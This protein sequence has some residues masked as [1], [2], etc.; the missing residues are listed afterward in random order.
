MKP[1]YE[2]LI[3]EVRILKEQIE[4]QK[5]FSENFEA[6]EQLSSLGHWEWDYD[7]SI[8]SWSAEVF[9]IFG[10]DKNNFDVSVENFENFIHEEDIEQIRFQREQMLKTGENLSLVH[11]IIRPTGEI[12]IVVEHANVIKKSNNSLYIIGT[13]QDITDKYNIEQENKLAYKKIELSEQKY[14]LLYNNT[15]VMLQSSNINGELIS[16]NEH[17]LKTLGYEYE[18]VI[19]TKSHNFLTQKS[20]QLYKERMPEFIKNGYINSIEA[21]AIKKNGEVIDLLISSKF[22]FDENGKPIQTLTNLIDITEKKHIQLE[23]LLAKK[24]A[25]EKEKQFHAIFDNSPDIIALTNIEGKFLEINK[26]PSGFLKE[27]FIGKYVTDF[28]SENE[29]AEFNRV[30]QNLLQTGI[31]QSYKPE[32]KQPNGSI[33]SWHVRVSAWKYKDDNIRLVIIFTDITEQKILEQELLLAKEKAEENEKYMI[34]LIEKSPLPMVITDENQD[35]ELFNEKFTSHFGY[36]RND[37]STAKSWWEKAY[38]DFEYRRKVQKSWEKA[39]NHALK[40]NTDIAQQEWEIT[41]KDRSKRTCQFNMMPLGKK[42]L[43]V[44]QDITE[45][46]KNQD[47]LLLAKDK[48][49]ENDRLKTAFLHNLSHE[50]RTPMN[51]IIGFSEMLNNNKIDENRKKQYIDIVINSS[52]QLLSIIN[53]VLIISSIE[54]KQEKVNFENINLNNILNHIYSIY[55]PQADLKKISLEIKFGLPNE[56]AEILTDRT[57]VTQII[58]NL[59][60]NALKFTS[61]GF[62]EMGYSLKENE[63]EFFVKDTGI[64]IKKELFFVIFERFR[65]ADYSINKK[66][67]GTGLGLSISEGLVKL[68]G[69]KIWVTS[70]LNNGSTFYFTIPY[71]KIQPSIIENYTPSKKEK[72]LTILV[73]EDEILNF[74]LIEE[75]LSD[76]NINIIHVKNGQEAVDYCKEN[77]HIDL[78]L[79][80]INMPIKD[81]Y[82]ATKEIKTFR[83][84]LPIVAQTAYAHDYERKKFSDIFDEYLTKPLNQNTLTKTIEKWT[85]C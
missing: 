40:N 46:R 26:V 29:A 19:G 69:G 25:S 36:T 17:W 4:K 77:N 62:V 61:K 51:A 37:I 7:K 84:D 16:V 22:L 8:L 6:V 78:V 83:K 27:D 56:E 21:Q 12:R 2:Q 41:I 48:A 52:N 28:F 39:I 5:L 54:T 14:K 68:L 82:T 13:V 38:P 53:D 71:N 49:E 18:E 34:Q 81:G 44:M 85:K 74:L 55:K 1:T 73:A 80:D 79:M 43:I 75:M 66:Y 30:V 15:P 47:A 24:Y 50:I 9:R 58:T 31:P 23:T 33:T 76:L 42:N 72:T 32:M 20:K 67:G 11:R 57:K 35:I 63:I 60:S 3:E 64:G 70:E 59:L 65:Q 45:V 10:V